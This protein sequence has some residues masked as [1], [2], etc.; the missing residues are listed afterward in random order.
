[1]V[2]IELIW[3][4]MR[5]NGE[6]MNACNQGIDLKNRSAF[7]TGCAGFIGFHTARAMLEKGWSIIGIDNLDPYYDVKLKQARLNEL[8]KYPQFFFHLLD[9][10]RS[11]EI[12]PLAEQ[13]PCVTHVIHLA[14]QAGVRHSLKEPFKYERCN[15]LGHL[16]IL[17]L[18]RL[19]PIQQLI[20]ASSSSVYG[21]NDKLPFS[22]NDAV[23]TPLSLYAATKR[24]TELISIAYAKLF[25]IPCTGLRFFTVYGPW[26]RPDM[27]AF[28]FTQSLL[29][30]KEIVLFNH[31]RMRRNFTYIDDIV[32]GIFG[33]LDC[34]QFPQGTLHRIYNLGSAHSENLL[35]FLKIL[36]T[37]L[38]VKGVVRLDVLQP[39]DVP[40]TIADISLSQKDLGFH[41]KVAI[42][43]GLSLFVQWYKSYY[44][45]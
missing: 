44:G 32:Q 25:N 6:Y 18:C 31:G 7:V 39:G 17:E 19:L 42:E 5:C 23:D 22:V 24:S 21:A 38:N 26:G 2:G 16:V 34:V 29:E 15:V 41:P 33:C 4:I 10:A 13:Y 20:Y 36:E 28:I 1:M 45:I 12:L 30:G 3:I 37:I 27:A 9:I 40:D 43:Q 8:R 14:A 35:Q 11:E